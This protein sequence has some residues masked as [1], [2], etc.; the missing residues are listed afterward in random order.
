M[1]DSPIQIP[2]QSGEDVFAWLKG[3]TPAELNAIEAHEPCACRAGPFGKPVADCPDCG[4]SGKAG[5][6]RLFFPEAL[7]YRNKAGTIVEERVMFVIP[8]E[9]DLSLATR[10]AVEHVQRQYPKRKV[11]TPAQAREL[12]G[13]IRFELLDT[14]ALVSLCVRHRDPPHGRAYKLHVFLAT[15]DPTTINDAFGRIEMLRRLWDV[16]V[17]ELDE[18]QF[19]ALAAE[20]ARVKNT[21]PFAVLAPGLHEPF[22]TRLA[23]ELHVSRTGKSST[24]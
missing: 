21:S 17:S 15:F 14:F 11:E 16:R 12:I 8:R 23:C 10:E 7:R 2:Q 9:D 13:E 5:I 18:E 6:P 20:I 22:I 4:G 24:G 1:S 3:K 19:W